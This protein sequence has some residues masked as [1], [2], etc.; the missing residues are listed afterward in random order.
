[1]VRS[2]EERTGR[3]EEER[4]EMPR[5]GRRKLAIEPLC[6]QGHRPRWCHKGISHAGTLL[7]TSNRGTGPTWA[8]RAPT[9]LALC[10]TT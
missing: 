7:S 6:R 1:M 5:G 3:S 9:P 8:L 4:T 10:N 2:S